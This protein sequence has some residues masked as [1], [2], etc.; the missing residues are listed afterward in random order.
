MICALGQGEYVVAVKA[1]VWL[2][3][4]LMWLELRVNVWCEC[5]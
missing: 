5:A 4:G 1:N 3:F 2:E